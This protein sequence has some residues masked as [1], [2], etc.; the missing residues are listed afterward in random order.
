MSQISDIAKAQNIAEQDVMKQVILNPHAI[1]R[2]IEIDEVASLVSFL[3]SNEASAITGS[4][5]SIDA[6]WTAT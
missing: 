4:S 3:C 5:M 6:G 1:K 2:L